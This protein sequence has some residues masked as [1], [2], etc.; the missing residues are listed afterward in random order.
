MQK[1]VVLADIDEASS[2]NVL[3]LKNPP[4]HAGVESFAKMPSQPLPRT[5]AMTMHPYNRHMQRPSS[6]NIITGRHTRKNTLSHNQLLN[7]VAHALDPVDVAFF[8]SAVETIKTSNGLFP[9]F[10]PLFV[11]TEINDLFGYP[12]KPPPPPTQCC[13]D[14]GHG[15]Q[16]ACTPFSCGH[17]FANDGE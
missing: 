2:P 14:V 4:T 6:K 11:Q 15:Q 3:L 16:C 13:K 1:S 17:T 12:K 10:M 5:K 7:L 9:N 8:F